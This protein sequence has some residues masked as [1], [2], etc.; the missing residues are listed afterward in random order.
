MVY[1]RMD[2]RMFTSPCSPILFLVRESFLACG[3]KDGVQ[4]C[5]GALDALLRVIRKHAERPAGSSPGDATA[6]EH[7]TKTMRLLEDVCRAEPKAAAFVTSSGTSIKTFLMLLR[8]SLPASTDGD[9]AVEIRALAA[10]LLALC[11]ICPEQPEATRTVQQILQ[12]VQGKWW[13]DTSSSPTAAT[14]PT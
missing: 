7:L 9:S 4:I 1:A 2:E 10:R 12:K 6:S 13:S 5:A 8:P 14:L 3:C 11:A